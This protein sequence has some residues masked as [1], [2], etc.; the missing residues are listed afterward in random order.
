MKLKYIFLLIPIVLFHL[1][2]NA[3][4]MTTD[5][6]PSLVNEVYNGR[7]NFVRS[8][9]HQRIISQKRLQVKA[10]NINVIG[11]ATYV[12]SMF[13]GSTLAVE[14]DWNLWI[15]I[16]CV[17]VISLGTFVTTIIWSKKIR[18]KADKLYDDPLS[19][20]ATTSITPNT[21]TSPIK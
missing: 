18:E 3:Q 15:Y 1:S 19:T 4:S 9:E 20:Q 10:D 12:L 7:I 17:T 13:L 16:P 8:S 11:D 21:F 14:N 5:S 2:T 6:L